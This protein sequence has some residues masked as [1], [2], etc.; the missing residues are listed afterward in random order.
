MKVLVLQQR[1]LASRQEAEAAD[2]YEFKASLVY[3][4]GQAGL[5][6]ETMSQNTKPIN[7][8]KTPCYR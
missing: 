2:F 4:A 1:I 5:Y 8:T 3:K 7:N 6:R